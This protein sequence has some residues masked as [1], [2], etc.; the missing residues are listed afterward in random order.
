MTDF[1]PTPP[2]HEEAP[3]STV[4]GNASAATPEG[5]G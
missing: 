1:E 4:P 2:S 5:S 3:R